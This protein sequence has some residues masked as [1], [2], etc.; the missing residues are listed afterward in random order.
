MPL[1]RASSSRLSHLAGAL[2]AACLGL[3]LVG[4]CDLALPRSAVTV[5][6]RRI[7][8][9]PLENNSPHKG[10]A[11][12]L[13]RRLQLAFEADGRMRV[14]RDPRHCDLILKGEI[15]QYLLEPTRW[16]KNNIPIGFKL[17]MA[18]DL[19]LIDVKTG[20]LLWAT[21]VGNGPASASDT[22]RLDSLNPWTLQQEKDYYRANNLGLPSEEDYAAR[23]ELLDAMA[24]RIVEKV[25]SG[26]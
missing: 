1:L 9:E 20:H 2:G 7:C 10:L 23:N 11:G 22:D 5:S 8:L 19:A 4:G 12:S 16:N 15:Q 24:S 6:D 18:V 26:F 25:F 13:D 14:T 17:R 3:A 21:Q